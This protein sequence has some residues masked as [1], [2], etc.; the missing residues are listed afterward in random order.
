M[1]EQRWF[2]GFLTHKLVTSGSQHFLKVQTGFFWFFFMWMCSIWSFLLLGL[3][4]RN[5]WLALALA[6]AAG[7]VASKFLVQFYRG[8]FREVVIDAGTGMVEIR[9][10][11]AIETVPLAQVVGFQLCQCIDKKVTGFIRWHN[12]FY[13]LI[14]VFKC[15]GE[16]HR[17]FILAT[18]TGEIIELIAQIKRDAKIEVVEYAG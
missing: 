16:I 9:R 15:G 4:I 3:I 12:Q 7:F 5:T 6:P 10:G 17:R 14:L 1:P 18:S 8:R 11:R 2:A 13:Q